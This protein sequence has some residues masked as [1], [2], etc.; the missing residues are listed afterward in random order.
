[1]VIKLLTTCSVSQ[2]FQLNSWID[3]LL[4]DL[5]VG[6][7]T[8]LIFEKLEATRDWLWKS[9]KER[10]NDLYDIKAVNDLVG[11][12]IKDNQEYAEMAKDSTY[13]DDIVLVVTDYQGIF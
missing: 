7:R 8:W 3:Q 9:V 1:M 13:R 2:N 4:L 5:F 12:C 6:Q 11:H 10:N